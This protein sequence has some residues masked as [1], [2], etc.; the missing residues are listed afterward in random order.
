MVGSRGEGGEQAAR[1]KAHVETGLPATA[2]CVVKGEIEFTIGDRKV[3]GEPGAFAHMP[4]G[5]PHGF[6]NRG[7]EDATLLIMF[8]PICNRE[9]YFRGLGRLTANGRNPSLEEL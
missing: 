3:V 5:E 8:Y 6:T 1:E 7:N 2:F 4:K 9:D